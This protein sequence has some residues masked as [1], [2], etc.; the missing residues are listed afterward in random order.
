MRLSS[1]WDWWKAG[2][3]GRVLAAA[4]AAVLIAALI[5]VGFLIYGPVMLIGLQALE[6]VPKKAA[7]TA[8]GFTGLFGYVGGSL[9]ANAMVGYAVDWYGW[10]GGF[11]LLLAGCVL[12]I[13]CILP[14]LKQDKRGETA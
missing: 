1:I 13:L 14:T 4:G 6:L 5:A 8:A 9:A 10:N 12:A 11:I 2:R 3:R 7:G